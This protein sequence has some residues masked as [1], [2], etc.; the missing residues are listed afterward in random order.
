YRHIKGVV[1]LEDLILAEPNTQVKSLMDEPI[2][3][4]TA[5]DQEEVAQLMSRYDMQAIPV[6]RNG[7]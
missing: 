1:E 6:V 3:V 7:W 5:T 4:N 2:F